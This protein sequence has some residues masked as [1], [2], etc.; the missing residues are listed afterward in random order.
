VIA[1]SRPQR[2]PGVAATLVVVAA[3]LAVVEGA[4]VIGAAGGTLPEVVRLTGG[5]THVVAALDLTLVVP[6]LL[7]AA[8]WL[9]AHNPWGHVVGVVVATKGV[10]YMAALVAT[11]LS[12]AADGYSGVTSEVPVWATI[13]VVFAVIAARLLGDVW[14]GGPAARSDT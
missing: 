6:F 14:D 10:V 3:G 13:G 11:T 7:L 9:R 12:T 5:S 4:Q 2:R 1:K 8:V